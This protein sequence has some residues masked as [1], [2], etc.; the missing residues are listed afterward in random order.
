MYAGIKCVENV[1]LIN[2]P[3][4][5]MSAINGY[6]K[7]DQGEITKASSGSRTQRFNNA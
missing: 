1:I 4:V 3:H 6:R 2:F 7:L 5:I